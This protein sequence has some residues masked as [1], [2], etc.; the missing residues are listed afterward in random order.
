MTTI[1]TAQRGE[2]PLEEPPLEALPLEE[3]LLEEESQLPLE[4][5]LLEEEPPLLPLEEPEP[6]LLLPE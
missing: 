4:E 1:T 6:R 2:G 5:L 3:L